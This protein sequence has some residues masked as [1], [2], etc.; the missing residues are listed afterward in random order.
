MNDEPLN[1]GHGAPLRLRNELHHGFKQ[2][3][4][5]N[6]IEFL[7][8]YSEVGSGYGGYCEDHKYFGRHQTI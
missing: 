8:S 2:V 4:W 5:I 3:K 7:A 1:Y 6:G